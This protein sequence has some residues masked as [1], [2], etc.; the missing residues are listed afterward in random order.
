MEELNE[1]PEFQMPQRTKERKNLLA[2]AWNTECGEVYSPPRVT[3]VVSKLGLRPAWSLDLTTVDPD[4]GMPWDFAVAAKRRK[5]VGLINRDKPLLLIACPMCG[6]FSSMNN[7]NYA[8]MDD[9]D[10]KEKLRKAMDHVKFALDL[11]LQQYRAGRLF[12]FEHPT[13]SSSWSTAMM[14]QVMGLEGV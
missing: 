2:E 13:S 1:K 7:L 12:L 5:A 9:A 3:Q 14:Q 6:P 10:A 11:C 8:K 4:D